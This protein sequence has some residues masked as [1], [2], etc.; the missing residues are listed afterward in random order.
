[1]RFI[2]VVFS[3]DG[4]QVL[5]N[6]SFYAKPGQKI[7]FIVTELANNNYQPDDRL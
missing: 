2:D 7:C 3:Y 1:M 5:N 6:V 4:K